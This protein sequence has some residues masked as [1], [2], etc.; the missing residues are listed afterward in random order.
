MDDISQS[1]IVSRFAKSL[2]E[3]FPK[4]LNKTQ[5]R[6]YLFYLLDVRHYSSSDSHIP[7]DRF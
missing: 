1:K 2:L 5:I 3:T 7:T 6:V 4:L